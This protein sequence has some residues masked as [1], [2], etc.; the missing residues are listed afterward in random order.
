MPRLT[1]LLFSLLTFW[2]INAQTITFDFQCVD[3]QPGETVCVDVVVTDFIQVASMQI[4]VTWDPTVLDYRGVQNEA[5]NGA[6]SNDPGPLEMI[7]I[8]LDPTVMGVSLPDGTTLFQI[9]FEIIGPPG[10]SSPVGISGFGFTEIGDPDSNIIPVSSSDCQINVL[11]A[12]NLAALLSSCGPSNVNGTIDITVFGG[13]APYS[14]TWTNTANAATG[15]PFAINAEGESSS[16]SVPPGNYDVTVTDMD[17][18]MVTYNITVDQFGLLANATGVAPTC[19]NFTNGKIIVEAIDGNAPYEFYWEHLTNSALQ[20]S[21]RIIPSG[22]SDSITSL[23]V[24]IYSIT[25]T[26]ES[27]CD[28]VITVDLSGSPLSLNASISAASCLGAENGRITLTPSGGHPLFGFFY[29][30]LFLWN[31]DMIQSG[32]IQLATLDPGEYC[33][34]ITDSLGCSS[35]T[36]CF[37]VPASNEI[38][39]DIQTQNA[40]CIGQDNGSATI[41]GLSNGSA[42]PPYDYEV[43]DSTGMLI[44]SASGAPSYDINGLGA[45]DYSVVVFTAPCRSDTIP[46]TIGE[47]AGISVD[48]LA[49]GADGCVPAQPTGVIS[50]LATGGV[51][52]PGSDYIYSWNPGGLMG[53]TIMDLNAGM[54]DLIVSDDNGCTAELT[55]TVPQ[56]TAP[57]IDSITVDNVSCSGAPTAILT[58]YISPGT[59]NT[60]DI[61]W[62]GNGM[63]LLDTNVTITG[64]TT[65]TLSNLGPGDYFLFVSDSLLCFRS[66]N[67]SIDSVD[68]VFESVVIDTPSC[69]GD[70]NGQ[71][72]VN[73]SGGVQPY[74]YFW[75]TGDTTQFNL[76][77][78]LIAGTYSV[79]ITDAE[80]CV[81]L[82]TTVVV[83]D[84]P[85]LSFMFSA[86]DSVS[87]PGVCDGGATLM[88]TGGL[89]GIPY[90]FFWESG[91]GQI[92][93]VSTASMLCE[94]WQTVTISQDNLC[95]FEDSVF[96][97]APNPIFTDSVN[98]VEPLCFGAADGSLM[99]TPG[100]GTPGYT[101]L[102]ESGNTDGTEMGLASGMH[103]FTISD[104]RGCMFIDSAF[105]G[106]PDSLVASL[107]SFLLRPIT[108]GGSNDGAIA[109]AASGGQAGT[110]MFAWDPDV[111]ITP[112]A[113]NLGP[114]TYTITVSDANGCMDTV[115][116]T[117]SQ[118]V[119]VQAFL[120][121]VLDP[122]C[123]GGITSLSIDLVTGGVGGNYTYSINNGQQFPSDSTVAVPPGFYTIFVFD[124]VGCSW[125]TMFMINNPPPIELS[126]EPVNPVVPLGDSTQLTATIGF[127]QN[128]IV[129]IQW[130]LPDGSSAAGTG[131]LSC[132][133]CFTPF[134]SNF[135]PITYTVTVVDSAGCTASI[136]VLVNVDDNRQVYI[137]NAFSPNLDGLNDVFQV[138]TGAGAQIINYIRIFDRW[139]DLIFERQNLAPSPNGSEGWDG[140][141]GGNG[142]EILMPGVYVYVI[143]I[144]FRDGSAPLVYRGDVTLIR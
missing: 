53:S 28:T 68:F 36:M 64:D 7:Y 99:I 75:S 63:A 56:A 135:Q 41:T 43:F 111:S 1:I 79:T 72:T 59:V 22:G 8:W 12:T 31:G 95:F 114:G 100:G 142:G 93:L 84:K 40:T 125:D 104:A 5:L 81:Q 54:Y 71:I 42:N 132:D 21:D 9:C 23:P 87:C 27:G 47:N 26:D 62:S 122:E 16:A 109:V 113:S 96:I 67:F 103:A 116:T 34:L 92:A 137:P 90:Q 101:F 33:L 141:Q 115:S 76:L 51:I 80:G 6:L 131:L 37:I 82:D 134:A 35:D 25:L 86:I 138:F 97:P 105:L 98:A 48:V 126:V 85:I 18:N 70:N 45:G 118:P 19:A 144:Q 107:D 4:S 14:Y 78:G 39:A 10:T 102:W 89:P 44:G 55:V 139:G 94:G 50:V 121:P 24:G 61:N 13:T 117:L 38:G 130:T 108:C 2:N 3:G 127:T 143:E 30:Y 11:N 32:T 15:G 140:T 69:P 88:P 57:A 106:Q 29:D 120:P 17:G 124:S 136:D 52:A 119:P 65:I 110:Y 20:G 133:A 49:V 74:T 128:P 91:E 73:V 60:L 112:F 83:P 66:S 129:G 123:N 77:P 46:F 58:A